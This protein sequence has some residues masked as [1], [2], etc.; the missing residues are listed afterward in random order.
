MTLLYWDGACEAY[1]NL[2]IKMTAIEF[3]KSSRSSH[4]FS[5]TKIQQ[6]SFGR[7]L[8]KFDNGKL[9]NIYGKRAKDRKFSDIK[10]KVI[11][12]IKLR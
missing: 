9:E 1:W 8:K 11:I 5:G 10:D 6:Q 12:C 7:M 4:F 2:E 3:L